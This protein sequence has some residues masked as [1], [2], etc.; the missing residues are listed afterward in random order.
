[1]FMH[2]SGRGYWAFVTVMTTE[3]RVSAS[4]LSDE[5]PTNGVLQ[6]VNAFLVLVT[7]QCKRENYICLVAQI[8]TANI[9]C[10]EFLSSV[11]VQHIPHTY[12]KEMKGK[13]DMVSETILLERIAQVVVHISFLNCVDK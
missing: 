4:H 9:A 7:M 12:Q 13:T 8:I 3:N 5:V 10:P 1:M 2:Q 6:M 11:T